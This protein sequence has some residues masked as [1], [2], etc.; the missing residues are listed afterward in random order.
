M[1]NSQDSLNASEREISEDPSLESSN[2]AEKTVHSSIQEDKDP[3]EDNAESLEN[4]DS[5]NFEEIESKESTFIED[6]DVSQKMKEEQIIEE[7]YQNGNLEIEENTNDMEIESIVVE[8]VDKY[9]K[10]ISELD[11]KVILDKW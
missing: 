10:R 11:E 7:S 4:G 3:I 5:N 9:H 1:D 2:V 6:T 8:S